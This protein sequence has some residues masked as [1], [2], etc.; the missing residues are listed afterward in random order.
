[1]NHTMASEC[2][3]CPAGW[4]VV[5]VHKGS[6]MSYEFNISFEYVLVGYVIC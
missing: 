2:Y 5:F 3:T 1:M 6:A 4:Y